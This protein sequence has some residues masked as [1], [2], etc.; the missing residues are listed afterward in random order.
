MD[1][2]DF[3]IT[4]EIRRQD[5]GPHLPEMGSFTRSE[6]EEEVPPSEPT[7]S[8]GLRDVFSG[9][10]SKTEARNIMVVHFQNLLTLRT[11]LERDLESVGAWI[12]SLEK[13]L[14]KTERG[15]AAAAAFPAY[16]GGWWRSGLRGRGPMTVHPSVERSLR[17]LQR[18]F[19]APSHAL[20]ASFLKEFMMCDCS[21]SYLFYTALRQ[22][23][24]MKRFHIERLLNIVK[25]HQIEVS[26]HI[27]TLDFLHAS[28]F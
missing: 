8:G 21:H 3:N 28:G 17:Y 25:R 6:E 22:E 11:N 24:E 13:I 14:E 18:C 4:L 5:V 16:S 20:L 15:L 7:G 27:S 10:E 1:G 26:G 9:D 23:Q 2:H 19:Y 12:A